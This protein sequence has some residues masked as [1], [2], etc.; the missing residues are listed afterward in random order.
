M[1]SLS[2]L[3]CLTGH[4]SGIFQVGNGTQGYAAA[5]IATAIAAVEA[6]AMIAPRLKGLTQ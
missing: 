2:L 5:A 3:G 4:R 6:A 1:L